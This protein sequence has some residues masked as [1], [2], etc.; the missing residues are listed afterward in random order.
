MSYAAYRDPPR[1][2]HLQDTNWNVVATLGVVSGVMRSL[3][4]IR[5]DPYGLA[6]F[7]ARLPDWTGY[8]TPPSDW[9]SPEGTDV[10]FQGR[11]YWK[12]EAPGEGRLRLYDFRHRTYAPKLGRFLQR[13][14]LGPWGDGSAAGNAY[15]GFRGSPVTANDAHGLGGMSYREFARELRTALSRAICQQAKVLDIADPQKWR[16]CQWV[17]I[18][19]AC[20]KCEERWWAGALRDLAIE[21]LKAGTPGGKVAKLAAEAAEKAIEKALGNLRGKFTAEWSVAYEPKNKKDA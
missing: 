5:Y 2:Y 9:E 12:V 13:D 16:G 14:P 6:Y 15:Y 19:C 8:A 20:N 17:V 4:A 7:Y 11:W 3:E 1:R 18:K 21:I 10:A